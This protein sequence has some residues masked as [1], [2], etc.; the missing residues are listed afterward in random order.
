MWPIYIYVFGV[1]E[2]ISE[3]IF[4]FDK[5]TCKGG[6]NTHFGQ[7]GQNVN[8]VCVIVYCILNVSFTYTIR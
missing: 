6:Q 2:L 1:K 8:N 4:W 5:N 7:I 3:D